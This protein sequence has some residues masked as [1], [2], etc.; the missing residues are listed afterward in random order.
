MKAIK[1]IGNHWIH[2]TTCLHNK[3]FWIWKCLDTKYSLFCWIQSIQI[4]DANIS[5]YMTST[6][7]LHPNKIKNKYRDWYWDWSMLMTWESMAVQIC[8]SKIFSQLIL[9]NF[10]WDF[11]TPTLTSRISIGVTYLQAENRQLT[12]NICLK[13]KNCEKKIVCTNWSQH[14]SVDRAIV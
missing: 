7:D 10:Y 11:I 6:Q 1:A 12:K 5:G 4:C 14:C 13:N 9:S 3:R 2:W 8:N